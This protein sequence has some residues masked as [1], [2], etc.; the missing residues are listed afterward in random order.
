M[1]N[2]LHCSL[3]SLSLLSNA[4]SR[5]IC[6][7]NRT[8]ARAGGG[9]ECPALD[10]N[11]DPTGCARELGQ[12]WKVHP[13][14]PI[15]AGET[16]TLADIDGPGAIQQIWMTP[17]GD[18]RF[19]ILRIYYDDQEIPSVECP[20]GDF[21]ASAFTSYSVY[22]PINSLAVCVNPGNAFNCY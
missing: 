12:G 9:R 5:S 2:G 15:P 3:D 13:C 14:D 19:T 21:F 22:A 8:G 11:G 18:Y 20:V 7:E 1:F 16:L 6:G 17:S 4:E 10:E